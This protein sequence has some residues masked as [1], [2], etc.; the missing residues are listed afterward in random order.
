[1]YVLLH[2]MTH[3]A[4]GQAGQTGNLDES[5]AKALGIEPPVDENGK[6]NWSAGVSRYFENNCDPKA[7]ANPK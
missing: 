4:Q 1:M 3:L 7:K 5:L 2:E 6:P